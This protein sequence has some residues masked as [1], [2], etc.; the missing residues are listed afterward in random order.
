MYV[1]NVRDDKVVNVLLNSNPLPVFLSLGG[2]INCKRK[3]YAH[4]S[5]NIIVGS[6]RGLMSRLI[7]RDIYLG[8]SNMCK[9]AYARAR[10]TDWRTQLAAAAS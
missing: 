8:L 6:E 3:Q 10:S 4:A 9:R 1:L 7:K 5:A 2:D